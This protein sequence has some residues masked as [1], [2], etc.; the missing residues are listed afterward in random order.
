MCYIH[1]IRYMYTYMHIN[2]LHTK[3]FSQYTMYSIKKIN[4]YRY[5]YRGKGNGS[6]PI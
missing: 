6:T 3:R 2:A 4:R 1:T 5:I